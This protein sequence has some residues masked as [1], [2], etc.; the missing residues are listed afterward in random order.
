MIGFVLKDDGNV[1][2]FQLKS[3]YLL[4]DEQSFFSWSNIFLLLEKCKVLDE[5]TF[6]FD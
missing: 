4:F 1:F 5:V 6:N 3:F 2:H